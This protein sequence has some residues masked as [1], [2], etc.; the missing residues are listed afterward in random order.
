MRRQVLYNRVTMHALMV[1]KPMLF[2]RELKNL[3][4]VLA[5][6]LAKGRTSSDLRRGLAGAW[7]V[8]PS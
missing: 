1:G 3:P 8:P 6:M 5:T 7:Q 4:H 2:L